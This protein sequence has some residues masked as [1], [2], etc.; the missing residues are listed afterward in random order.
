M[1]Y[2][3]YKEQFKLYTENHGLITVNSCQIE[4]ARKDIIL[5]SDAVVVL[6]G[7]V[8]R[9]VI[10]NRHIKYT[11]SKGTHFIDDFN[12]KI[13]AAVLQQK[14]NW[15]ALQIK[16]LQLVMPEHY[17]FMASNR[18]FIA[19]GILDNYLEKVKQVHFTP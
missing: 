7:T 2:T 12:A 16:N 11:L 8:L 13:N 1:T 10:K 18:F 3:S 9:T 17:T 6:Y 4:L 19:L 14:E 15:S 5:I